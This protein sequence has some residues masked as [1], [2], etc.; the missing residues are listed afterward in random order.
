MIQKLE[1]LFHLIETVQQSNISFLR[2][3]FN[4]M[5]SKESS[6]HLILFNRQLILNNHIKYIPI[7]LKDLGIYDKNSVDEVY[8]NIQKKK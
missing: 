3:K 4:E 8:F 2:L 1:I 5:L 6:Q 7:Y